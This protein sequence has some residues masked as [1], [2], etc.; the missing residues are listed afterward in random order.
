LNPGD[1][2]DPL[3]TD[4]N[5]SYSFGRGASTLYS[6]FGTNYGNGGTYGAISLQFFT[7]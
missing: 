6:G 2:A 1:S 3:Y 7:T 4:A 5:W